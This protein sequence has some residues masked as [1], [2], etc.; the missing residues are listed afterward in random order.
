MSDDSF[1][2]DEFKIANAFSEEFQY[3]YS[4]G[5]GS[6]SPLS[7]ASRTAEHSEDPL[8]DYNTMYLALCCTKDSAAGPDHLPGRFY[9]SLA[10]DLAPSLSTIVQQSFYSGHIPDVERIEIVR[11]VFKLGSRDIAAHYRPINLKCIACKIME[12]IV[13]NAMY[14][15]LVVNSLL[16]PAQHSF[17]A[18][19]STILSLLLTH[20]EFV[21]YVEDKSNVNVILLN[22]AKTFDVVDHNFVLL[23]LNAYGFSKYTLLWL[24]DFLRDRKQFV[25]FDDNISAVCSVPSGV[26]QGCIIGSLLFI[27]F[28]NDLP[29]VIKLAFIFLYADDLKLLCGVKSIADKK[30]IAG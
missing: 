15:L 14:D 3:N 1:A 28:I 30:F 8:F 2:P 4:Y 18:R 24:A 25:C 17:R 9:R 6:D 23:K 27:L 20:N 16:C 12:S 5:C 19:R 13:R 22:F 11:P 7:F 21:I 26:I 29:D 10:A